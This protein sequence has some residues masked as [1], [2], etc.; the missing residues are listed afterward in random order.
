MVRGTGDYDCPSRPPLPWIAARGGGGS[1]P[2]VPCDRRPYFRGLRYLA[3]PGVP[4]CHCNTNFIVYKWLNS[5]I[6]EVGLFLQEKQA[7]LRLFGVVG[8]VF[9]QLL[10]VK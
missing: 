3:S 2:P 1:V 4:E 7:C 6:M 9:D 10:P 5:C 8:L